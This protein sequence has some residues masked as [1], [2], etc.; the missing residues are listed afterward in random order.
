[1]GVDEKGAVLDADQVVETN[2]WVRPNLLEGRIIL[3]VRRHPE[4]GALQVI[5]QKKK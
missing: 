2:N 3:A 5:K 4:T 1:M